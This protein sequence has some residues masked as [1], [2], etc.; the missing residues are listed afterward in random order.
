MPGWARQAR[1]VARASPFDMFDAMDRQFE[2][3]DRQFEAMQR[4][5]D[6]DMD[7]AMRMARD[8]ERQAREAERLA[9][10]EVQRSLPSFRREELRPAPNVD[11]TRQEERGPGTYRYYERIQ[12]T[13]GG[14]GR[15]AYTALPPPAAATLA[16][17]PGLGGGALLGIAVAV[18]GW[19]ALT[20]AFN[21]NYHLT[22]YAESKRWMLL[23][24]WPLLVLFSPKFREQWAAVVRG[25]RPFTRKEGEQQG[26]D[27]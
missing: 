26:K 14:P 11:I 25:E 10:S 5:M 20:A 13:S 21:R 6:R 18:G 15:G 16:P 23:L 24:L 1:V 22:V 9:D 4:Q 2:L 17:G 8:A 3:M 7:S 12:I 27:K 19:A